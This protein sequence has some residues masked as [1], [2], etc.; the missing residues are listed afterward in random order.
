MFIESCIAR[1]NITYATFDRHQVLQSKQHE[2]EKGKEHL[3]FKLNPC[4]AILHCIAEVLYEESSTGLSFKVMWG[5]WM[6]KR[7]PSECKAII[8]VV[9]RVKHFCGRYLVILICGRNL[10]KPHWLPSTRIEGDR[11]RSCCAGA[12]LPFNNSSGTS[13]VSVTSTGLSWTISVWCGA[14]ARTR[15]Q[16]FG[17]DRQGSKGRHQRMVYCAIMFCIDI[18]FG[19]TLL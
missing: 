2:V 14:G 19:I 7:R 13:D 11:C 1:I 16:S 4:S 10:L 6:Q 15:F 8:G 9:T 3:L 12:A 18:T 17:H 5:R